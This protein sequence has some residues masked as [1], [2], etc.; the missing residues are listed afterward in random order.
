VRYTGVAAGIIPAAGASAAIIGDANLNLVV[1][2]GATQLVDF[3]PGFGQIFGFQVVQSGFT[4]PPSYYYSSTLQQNS[5]NAVFQFNPYN[6]GGAY[7]AFHAG[8]VGGGNPM[9][10]AASNN[11]GYLSQGGTQYFYSMTSF[12]GTV[13]DLAAAGTFKVLFGGVTSFSSTFSSGDWAGGQRGYLGFALFIGADTYF[14]WFDVEVAAGGN[15]MTVY[16]W[17]LNT[18]SFESIH[19]GDVPA[20]GAVGLGALAM[21]AA[22]IRRQRRSKAA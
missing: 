17:G 9:R 20:P 1:N 12:L 16:A 10:L 7:A 6:S 14:G 22:G 18:T 15:Q 21:G 2:P 5:Y 8:S 3:G 19:V 4:L 11:I 13:H